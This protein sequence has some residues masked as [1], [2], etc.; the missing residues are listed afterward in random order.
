MNADC[1]EWRAAAVQHGFGRRSAM[2]SVVVGVVVAAVVGV[3]EVVA[4]GIV[5]AGGIVMVGVVAMGAG[6]RC[7]GCWRHL[8]RR[9]Q[10][11]R[12]RSCIWRGGCRGFDGL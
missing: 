5:A 8:G 6:G 7:R 9:R 4:V 2:I 3:G 10:R 11:I 12:R 1:S